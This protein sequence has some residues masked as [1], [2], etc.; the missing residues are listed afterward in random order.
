M[1]VID[2]LDLDFGLWTQMIN[3]GIADS[4]VEAR[5]C[6]HSGRPSLEVI[7]VVTLPSLV[8]I[9]LEVAVARSSVESRKNMWACWY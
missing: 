7:A 6:A 5:L 2:H 1:R 9:L 3:F 8:G 4:R